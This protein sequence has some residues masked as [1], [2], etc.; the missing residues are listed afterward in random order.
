MTKKLSLLLCVFMGLSLSAQDKI[1]TVS[2]DTLKVHIVELSEKYVRFRLE[3]NEKAP[4]LKMPSKR[5]KMLESTSIGNHDFS[6]GNRRLKKK[7]GV[8]LGVDFNNQPVFASIAL[9]YFLTGNTQWMIQLGPLSSR[10]LPALG[11]GVNYHFLTKYNKSGFSPYVGAHFIIDELT[12][13]IQFP[14][15]V[16]YTF[17][18]YYYIDTYF[19]SRRTVFQDNYMTN[20]YGHVVIGLRIGRRF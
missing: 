6:Y 16:S 19:A 5:I 4:V 1:I 9:D 20:Y 13:Y 12:D 8:S 7:W 18:N 17:R 10:D 3:D 11:M 2:K 15:G 14:I